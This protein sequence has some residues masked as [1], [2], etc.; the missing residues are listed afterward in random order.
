MPSTDSH[1][2]MYR[3]EPVKTLFP[4]GAFPSEDI[5]LVATEAEL[6][7]MAKFHIPNAVPGDRL[8]VAVMPEGTVKESRE[9]QLLQRR[10]HRTL[11]QYVSLLTNGMQDVQSTCHNCEQFVEAPVGLTVNLT[12]LHKAIEDVSAR[13]H[14]EHLPLLDCP[15]CQSSHWCYMERV[16][17]KMKATKKK[18]CELNDEMTFATNR[19]ILVGLK[20]MKVQRLSLHVIRFEPP[21]AENKK[22]F[23]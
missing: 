2:T 19:Q 5:P 23:S 1:V 15:H 13:P 17:K 4:R 7:D 3:D 21:K 16:A 18:Y 8:K 14:P 11:K 22:D 20:R 6:L 10:V 12:D 9:I